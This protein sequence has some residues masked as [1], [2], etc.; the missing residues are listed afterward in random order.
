VRVLVSGAG[1]VTWTPGM[2]QQM[3]EAAE[4]ELAAAGARVRRDSIPPLNDLRPLGDRGDD[5]LLLINPNT[6]TPIRFD[7]RQKLAVASTTAHLMVA[8]GEDFDLVSA[9]E[10]QGGFLA[11][12]YL[13]QVGCTD[14][15]FVGTADVN[16][17]GELEPL[18]RAR[19][20][21]L[22]AG[23][24]AELPGS[25]LFVVRRYGLV[26][27]ASAV[28]E[29]QCLT[30]RPDGIFAASDE[31]AAGFVAGAAAFGLQ[32]DRDYHIV[33]FDGQ[34][35]YCVLDGRPLVSVAVP[36]AELGRQAARLLI[37]RLRHPQQPPRSLSIGCSLANAPILA[38]A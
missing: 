27:G 15:A 3:V 18:C 7:P 1:L 23:F 20:R 34:Q 30:R 16:T 21:G 2:I 12:R 11:G 10:E 37:E 38:D 32:H 14:P 24:G 13:R 17:P 22:E 29:F 25:R 28:A 33:G 35:Q 36:A 9:N 6:S 19:L 5:A 31:L 8:A 26:S 4:D